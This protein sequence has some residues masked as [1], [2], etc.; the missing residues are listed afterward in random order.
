VGLEPLPHVYPFRFV[1]RTVS[2][3]GPVSGSVRAVVTGGA[4]LP[5]YALPGTLCEMLAQAVLLVE[6]GDA[7][8]GRSGFLAGISDFEVDR[9]PDPG[10]VLTVDVRLAGRFGPTVKFVGE[11]RDDAGRRVAGG[12]LTVKQGTAP[13]S[14]PGA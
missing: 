3:T 10:D 8:L 1:D 5:A 13:P 11:I 2:V 6:G 4:K 12:A 7:D 14:G 9:L